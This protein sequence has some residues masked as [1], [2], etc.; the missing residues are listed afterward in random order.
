VDDD[1]EVC[2]QCGTALD[3]TEDPAFEPE[4]DGIMGSEVFEADRAERTRGNLVTV[5]NF[6]TEVEAHM[7]RARLEAAGFHAVVVDEFM[8]SMLGFLTMNSG[9]KVLVL[10]KEL[11]EALE[12]ARQFLG[13]KKPGPAKPTGEGP[14]T[15]SIRPAEDSVRDGGSGFFTEGL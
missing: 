11:E 7:L 2:W 8:G 6:R 9:V 3:G 5:G 4:L 15:D 12:Q 14:S 1:F 10:E 13:E